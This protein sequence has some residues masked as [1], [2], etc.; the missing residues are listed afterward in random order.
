MNVMKKTFFLLALLLGLG[1]VV[2]APVNPQTALRVAENFWKGISSRVANVEQVQDASFNNL[3]IFHV[4]ET[5]GFVIVAADDRA[6]PIL[7]YGDDDVAGD[8]GPET[9]FWL[10]Q[11][12]REIE[13]LASGAV[14]NDDAILAD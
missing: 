6:Y 5:E 4:N 14:R 7:A 10:G 11:Y 3:Y 8:M 2:A 1:S 13:A 12:E 9:R